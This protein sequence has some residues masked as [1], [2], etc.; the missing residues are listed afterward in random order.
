MTNHTHIYSGFDGL[1]MAYR[2]TLP[3]EL[4]AALRRAKAEASE[5]RRTVALE[6]KGQTFLVGDRGGIGGYAFS[7]D[8]GIMGAN[9]WF[10][11]P[12]TGD[13]WGARVSS[14]S[15]PLALKAIDAVKAEHDTFLL[16]LGMQFGEIDRR[17]SRIDY[18]I[19]FLIPGFEIDPRLFVSHS[20]RTKTID[21]EFS[22]DYRGDKINGIRIGKMPNSQIAI[23]DKRREITEKKKKYWWD[24]W[25]EGFSDKS[26][27]LN[28][29][30]E[31][32][33]FEFRAGKNFLERQFKRK[34]WDAFSHNPADLFFKIACQTRLA[35]RLN[36]TNRARWPNAP[37]WNEIQNQLSQISIAKDQIDISAEII[38]Q[39]RFEYAE[40]IC[41][42]T[43]GLIISQA[44]FYGLTENDLTPLIEQIKLD[45]AEN[46]AANAN[47]DHDILEQRRAGIAARFQTV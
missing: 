40:T 39:L 23:Y 12:G 5:A 25:Q 13:P 20:N 29:K 24:I 4:H 35:E 45:L 34:T 33:R 47:S 6:Y 22:A 21:A 2:V 18:A 16:N 1:D 46:L 11:E 8:T 41:K 42:Q 10:K 43:V 28:S 19:D 32:W 3:G 30:S 37:I 26:H 17:I 7:I 36:D 14:R 44:A 15:L 31:I 9:W 27:E 38:A